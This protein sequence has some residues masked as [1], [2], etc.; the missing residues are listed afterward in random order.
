[1]SRGCCSPA[2]CS[3]SRNASSVSVWKWYTRWALSPTTSACWR[4]GSW[5]VTPVGQL[6]VWQVWACRQPKAN[7]KPRAL[8]H[9]SAP[10]A[11]MRATSK[12][13]ITLPA[14]PI[15]MR[16]R[17]PAPRSV[18]CTS[19]SPS[20]RGAPTWSV[21]STG[22][23]PVPPSVPSTTMKS[24]VMPDSSMA[25]TMPN[26]SQLWPM[27][28]LKPVG[29]PPESV[30][31]RSTNCSNSSGVENALCDAGE[32]QSTPTG[33][34]RASAISTVTLGPG[35]TP[36]WP[37]LAPWLSLISIIFTCASVACSV[38]RSALKLPS[39][40]RQPK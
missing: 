12:A 3:N 18:L 28:S 7:M 33:T 40:L 9:Q 5:V 20:C 34:P 30:R 27:H 26:H 22:A 13:V 36:P 38:K 21:N 10:K 11:S 32:T 23:A 29:L 14:Q 2:A 17:R 35:N 19:V 24:G 16:S 37:G 6:P 31:K 15:L 39:V 25:L 4:I 1:M 8:L